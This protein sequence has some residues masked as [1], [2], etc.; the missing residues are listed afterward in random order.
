MSAKFWQKLFKKHVE[1]LNISQQCREPIRK[2]AVK[3][4]HF[5]LRNLMFAKQRA[6]EPE[7]LFFTAAADHQYKT[8]DKIHRLAI[9]Y[10]LIINRVCLQ[11]VSQCLLTNSA[12]L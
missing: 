3:P 1:D 12:V 2:E 4:R 9:A 5:W 7:G 10:F 6:E 8:D 11:D